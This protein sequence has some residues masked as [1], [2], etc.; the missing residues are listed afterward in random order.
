MIQFAQSV[1][2]ALNA[3][4]GTYDVSPQIQTIDSYNPGTNV[5]IP[6][7]AFPTSNV[8]AA[9]IRYAVY[10]NTSTTTLSEVGSIYMVYNPSNGS[11]L[12]WETTREYDGNASISFNVTDTG[13][14]QFSTETLGG[15]NHNGVITYA[16]MAL[17]NS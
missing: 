1:E 2:A 3:V 17:Q 16:G 6:N 8:R 14:V 4:A 9:M 15:I 10:R 7:L 13:Q 5:D 12:K 11:G